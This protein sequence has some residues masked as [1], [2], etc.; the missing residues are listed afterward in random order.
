MN[1][2]DKLAEVRDELRVAQD[3]GR[4]TNEG[5]V[6]LD[7][8]QNPATSGSF[9]AL[10]Q[11]LSL[12]FSDEAIGRVR[13]L[14]SDVP[15]VV[16]TGMKQLGVEMSPG[17]AGTAVERLGMR[18][19]QQEYP[20]RAV[21][22][23]LLGGMIP[24]LVSRGRTAP[25]SISMATLK[26]T[27]YGGVGGYGAGEGEGRMS[28]AA[29]GA[30]TAGIFTPAL[31]TG[32]KLVGR[33][34]RSAADSM[35][36]SPTR[37]GTDSARNAIREALQ[38]DVG[39]VDQAIQ[40]ILSKQGK[41]YTLADIGPNTRAYLDAANTLPGPSKKQ[42]Q[43]FLQKR[44][45]GQLARITSDIQDAFGT[46]A[47][48]FDEFN[49]L[50]V[51]RSDTGK[52]LYQRAFQKQ[53]PVTTEFTSLL[54]RPSFAG[55]FER[56]K[57]IAAER[58]VKLPDVRLENGKLLTDSGEVKAIDT[59][60][61]HY[62]K[63]G[64][65]DLVFTGKSPQSGIG[66]TQLNSIK[67]TRGLFL[68]YLDRNNPAYKQ[69]RNYWADDTAAM[70]AMQNGRAFFRADPDELAADIRRMSESEKEAFRIGAMQQILDR[71]G[72]AQVGE[73]IMAQPGN[74][75][76][77]LLKDPKNVRLMR[78][79]FPEG[80]GGQQLFD[81][82]IKNL[83]DEVEMKLTSQTVLTGSQTA[84]RQEAVSRIRK[85]A[86]KEIPRGGS[87]VDLVLGSLRR[88]FKDA[89]EA[90][91]RSTASEIVRTLTEKD[92]NKLQN[93]AKELE[94]KRTVDVFRKIAP[95]FLPSIA[96]AAIGPYSIGSLS[97]QV[98][99]NVSNAVPGLLNLFG[100]QE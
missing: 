97:G 74:Q 69:A 92:P 29:T 19:Y 35:F 51:A 44:D 8:I 28:S 100:T 70:D 53:I 81:R 18:S 68:N 40:V 50:K 75:A 36:S 26:A 61:L 66:A 56:A 80:A 77:N 41:P 93:I 45:R 59:E 54:Q 6:L 5:K 30:A 83:S 14:F 21:T 11:G 82:F 27:G 87:F 9:G 32:G 65:D 49:A 86:Q 33:A 67:D 31:Q 99:P 24:A 10:L 60:L 85:E 62:M 4:L 58:G 52:S 48:F 12:N 37:M 76:R 15:E 39:S 84:G 34:Y 7:A 3:R 42:A 43:E 17:E 1:F 95:E 71:V 90:Q 38:A 79:T 46:N 78:L 94:G 20:V 91:L 22:S 73:T 25:E 47:S 23:E 63:M 88:D 96:R 16:S 55:A 2:T 64:L 72:G 89:E 98:A 13:G 57:A